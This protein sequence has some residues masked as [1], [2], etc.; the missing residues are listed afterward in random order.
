MSDCPHHTA[1]RTLLFRQAIHQFIAERRD[2]KLKGS[3]EDSVDADKY[4]PATWLQGAAKRVGR[5]QLAT[6]TPKSPH[7]SAK[8]TALHCPPGQ[9]R[10]HAL[11][12]THSLSTHTDDVVGDAAA[13]DVNKFLNIQIDGKRLLDW[14]LTDDADAIAALHT[15]PTLARDMADAFKNLIRTNKDWASH[16]LAKQ[17]YWWVDSD[18]DSDP[19]DNT[20]YHLLQPMFSS[21]FTHALHAD[22]QACRFGQDNATARKARRDNIAHGT[23]YLEYKNLV[24][25]KQ[26]GSKPQNISQLTSERGGVNYLLN[27][28]PPKW[29]TSHP[30]TLLGT[31]SCLP[32]LKDSAA[33]RDLIREL[34]KLLKS[35]PK[36][37]METRQRREAIEQ[38]LGAE[39][40][41]YGAQ[42][43]A[44]LPA[45]WTRNTQCQ[46]ARCEQLWLDSER[47]ALVQDIPETERTPEDQAFISEYHFGD[48]PDQVATRFAHWVN[49]HLRKADLPVGD[50]ETRHWA[51]Q[52]V[53]DAS[54]PVPMQR[55]LS[56][57]AENTHD[58]ATHV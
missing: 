4:D 47:A 9:L 37:N 57:T 36:S 55:R 27:A 18:G 14:F 48:W 25:R 3:S 51:R 38:A 6:H 40:A 39:L 13:L 24:I 46:L 26:G 34:I 11:I 58:E 45:G 28:L 8:G 44:Q 16:P 20:C 53:V 33:V 41:A 19:A 32:R 49:A 42:Q 5:I 54:W 10:H 31:D 21:S 29:D 22:I 43:R 2:A 56:N 1:P 52:A 7:P 12:G 23:P 30:K 50:D 35:N 17:V 15:D